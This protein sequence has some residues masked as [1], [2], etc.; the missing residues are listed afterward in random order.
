MSFKRKYK[1]RTRKS[2]RTRKSKKRANVARV[3]NRVLAKK[4]ETKFGIVSV[5]ESNVGTLTSPTASHLVL[6]NNPSIGSY[7]YMRQGNKIRMQR[8]D[9]RGHV[10]LGDANTACYVKI[11]VIY[12]Q[13]FDDPLTDFLETQSATFAPASTAIDSIYARVNTTKYKVLASKTL[14]IGTGSG[15]LN[16]KMFRFNI[17]LHD[18]EVRWDQ[19]ASAPENQLRIFYLA[20]RCDNDD[21]LGSNIEMTFNSKLY[22][23]DY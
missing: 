8:V 2:R 13:I 20:R 16:T 12:Q 9:I 10:Q 3:V 1:P 23:K 19:Q 14:T 17:N 15:F 6:L 7:V 22:Y 4:A 18:K 21:S 11:W 5:T